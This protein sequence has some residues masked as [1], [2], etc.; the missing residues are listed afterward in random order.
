MDPNETM[1][2]VRYLVSRLL[3]G[4]LQHSGDAAPSVDTADATELAE[5]VRALDGWLCKGG[6]LPTEWARARTIGER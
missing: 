2:H 4:R 3:D 6:F 5:H 1:A